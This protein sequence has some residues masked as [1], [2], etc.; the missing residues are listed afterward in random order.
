MNSQATSSAASAEAAPS[1]AQEERRSIWSYFDDAMCNAAKEGEWDLSLNSHTLDMEDGKLTFKV[2]ASTKGFNLVFPHSTPAE[3]SL[4][5]L[6]FTVSDS[7]RMA[8]GLEALAGQVLTQLESHR[9][10]WDDYWPEVAV[11][12]DGVQARCLSSRGLAA[13]FLLGGGDVFLNLDM[14][15][16][17]SAK[18]DTVESL[19][20]ELAPKCKAGESTWSQL[21]TYL[22]DASQDETWKLQLG[23]HDLQMKNDWLPFTIF[24]SKGNLKLDSGATQMG[25]SLNIEESQLHLLKAEIDKL[26]KAINSQLF[27]YTHAMSWQQSKTDG[28]KWSIAFPSHPKVCQSTTGSTCYEISAFL[29]VPMGGNKR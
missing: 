4:T 3:T 9:G 14:E 28:A 5:N 24:A 15:V 26:T 13:N 25:D 8:G 23:K 29:Q 27:R 1:A 2:Q 22:K 7:Q 6:Q 10:Q 17:P 20:N 21:N 12:R 18:Q 11:D 16:D 19:S